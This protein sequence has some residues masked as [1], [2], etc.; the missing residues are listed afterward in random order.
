MLTLEVVNESLFLRISSMW[1]IPSVLTNEKTTR[2][3]LESIYKREATNVQIVTPILVNNY[4]CM[5]W[6]QE[7]YKG[8]K[9][10]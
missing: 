6:Q 7:H 10:Y 8:Q 4:Y 5:G 9:S 1:F 2:L 3:Y